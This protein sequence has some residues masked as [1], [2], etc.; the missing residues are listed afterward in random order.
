MFSLCQYK[1]VKKRANQTLEWSTEEKY[2][3][4]I[5]LDKLSLGRAYMLKAVAESGGR[6][7]DDGVWKQGLTKAEKFLSQAVDGLREAG[8]QHYIPQG[9]LARTELYRYQ[10][11]FDKAWGDLEEV[12]EI[13]ERGQMNLYLADFHLES[14][15]VCLAEGG[16]EKEAREHYEEA[17]KRVDDMGY[18]RRDPEVLLIQAELEIVEGDKKQAQETLE[19]AKKRIDEMGCHRWDSEVEILKDRI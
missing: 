1:E 15:R 2:L 8:V 4:D 16:N 11:D 19:K 17:K 14:A 9:L 5:G 3:L 18:H 7:M 12:K 10:H 6:T 13:A